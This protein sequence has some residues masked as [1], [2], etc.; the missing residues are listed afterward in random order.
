MRLAV[1][2]PTR[3]QWKRSLL[4]VLTWP[5]TRQSATFEHEWKDGIH[6]PY[7]AKTLST[8][9]ATT[10]KMSNMDESARRTTTTSA[11]SAHSPSTT[12][13]LSHD[14]DEDSFPN[15]RRC[16]SAR[17]QHHIQALLLAPAPPALAKHAA[18]KST[19]KIKPSQKPETFKLQGQG[20]RYL[21]PK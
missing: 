1:Y 21:R 10:M 11:A 5:H 18:R 20:A 9:T 2:L 8:A 17:L 15:P 19:C 3:V 6:F 16:Q 4:Q 14:N 7:A 12:P 13:T